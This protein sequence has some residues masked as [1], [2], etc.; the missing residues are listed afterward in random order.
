MAFF[1]FATQK[2]NK[3]KGSLNSEVDSTGSQQLEIKTSLLASSILLVA[4][5]ASNHN[6]RVPEFGLNSGYPSCPFNF[7]FFFEMFIFLK[8]FIAFLFFLLSLCE[9]IFLL[10][11]VPFFE[12]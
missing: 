6:R 11:M 5:T 8:Y 12:G 3:K 10:T 7:F 2:K 9:I 4:A 1:Q